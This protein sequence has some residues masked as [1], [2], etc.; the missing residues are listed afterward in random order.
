MKVFASLAAALL[1]AASTA[2]VDPLDVNTPLNATVCEPL[3]LSWSGGTPPY[4]AT[5]AEVI[6][7]TSAVGVD[8]F[9]ATTGTSFTWVV[10]ILP[11][12]VSKGGPYSLVLKVGDSAGNVSESALFTVQDSTNH[13]CLTASTVSTS[14]A[15]SPTS[16][17]TTA[18][19]PTFTSPATP[20]SESTP[21]Q[22]TA[23]SSKLSEG[24][25]WGIGLGVLAALLLVG[26]WRLYVLR[27]RRK[28]AGNF[29]DREN[30]GIDQKFPLS[31][32][33]K[34]PFKTIE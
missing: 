4:A 34:H 12:P 18:A 23:K 2:A 6:S 15:S 32:I 10:D 26:L 3:T 29:G 24:Q 30:L 20:S 31:P 11:V 22:A 16:G 21:V 28:S 13:S 17:T 33:Q 9:I 7:S 5:V 14:T 25:I 19:I 8:T 1:F 27:T